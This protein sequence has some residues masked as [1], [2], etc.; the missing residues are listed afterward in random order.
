MKNPI[1]SF[2]LGTTLAC[3][4]AFGS[5]AL[6][7]EVQPVPAPMPPAATTADTQAMTETYANAAAIAD[8]YEIEAANLALERSKS[9]PV[10]AFA[11]MLIADHTASTSKLKVLV[12]Q[13]QGALPDALD[14]KH[15]GMIQQLK[16]ADDAA[17]DQLFMQQ[18]MTAH[19]DAL[20]LHKTYADSGDQDAFRSFASETAK[21]VQK[22]IDHMQEMTATAG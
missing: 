20:T 12:D 11:N 9:E 10:K 3:G 5:G 7:Q 16:D 22:H 2:L 18:Q 1:R 21:T 13:N 6:A 8:M 17:F 4:T 15:E 14:E 19:D